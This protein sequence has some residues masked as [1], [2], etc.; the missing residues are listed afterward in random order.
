MTVYDISNTCTC[1]FVCILY[2]PTLSKSV[3]QNKFFTWKKKTLNKHSPTAPFWTLY[4]LDFFKN[5]TFWG[6]Q[7]ICKMTAVRGPQKPSSKWCEITPIGFFSP[8][9]YSWIFGHEK[10]AWF[11]S[12]TTI[13]AR[14]AWPF[15]LVKKNYPTQNLRQ[16]NLCFGVG[17]TLT[18]WFLHAHVKWHFPE[19][20][21]APPPHKNRPGRWSNPSILRCVFTPL[22][23]S[24][25]YW[26][27]NCEPSKWTSQSP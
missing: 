22:R 23:N 9:L 19:A 10:R 25:E 27:R 3:I 21:S 18:N 2:Q 5:L 14:L 17:G 8:Q 11:T 13:G 15:N 4:S 16:I 26:S 6:W 7:K 20:S 1:I 24:K 12:F